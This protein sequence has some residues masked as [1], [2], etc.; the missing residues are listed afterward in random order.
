M[1]HIY[2]VEEKLR[3]GGTD[4]RVFLS[5]S[6][7]GLHAGLFSPSSCIS[8]SQLRGGEIPSRTHINEIYCTT[9][10]DTTSPLSQSVWKLSC[11]GPDSQLADTAVSVLCACVAEVEK[12][13][14]SLYK[15]T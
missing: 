10:K 9:L 12:V 13:A 5:S 4:H 2:H 7:L 1:Y 6:G 11:C 3:S 15:M 14:K 8:E